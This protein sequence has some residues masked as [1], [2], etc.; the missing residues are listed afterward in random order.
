MVAR[1]GPKASRAATG[2]TRPRTW[3][4]VSKNGDIQV[5]ERVNDGEPKQCQFRFG[6]GGKTRI[7][8][9]MMEEKDV[10]EDQYEGGYTVWHGTLHALSYFSNL[11][12]KE[13]E[14]LKFKRTIDIGC[15]N[16][17]LGIFALKYLKAFEVFFQDLNYEVLQW[18]TQ[19]NLNLNSIPSS[20]NIKLLGG[21][22]QNCFDMIPK[23]TFSLILTSDTVYRQKNFE[24]LHNCFDYLL[25]HDTESQIYVSG[26][27]MYFGND[28]GI[29]P[30]LDFV[31]QRDVFKPEVL[32]T[33]EASVPH[34]LL[35]LKRISP[36]K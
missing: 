23:N 11:N 1:P 17:V 35:F 34:T 30:F 13:F 26:K 24:V 33:D 5:W 3:R 36:K 21:A 2:A 28:G 14:K 4:C 29:L 12:E 19:Q 18:C 8:T 15:G 6:E 10:V 22:W 32:S 25:D 16:G 27:A 9:V 20:Q 31:K 7:T